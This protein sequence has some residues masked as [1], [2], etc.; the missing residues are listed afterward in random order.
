MWYYQNEIIKSPRAITLGNVTYPKNI[1]KDK[2]FLKANGI[3]PYYEEPIDSRYYWQG[4]KTITETDTEVVASYE[5]IPRLIDD[6]LEVN[7]DGSPML[8]EEGNQVVTKGL[9]DRLK[10]KN[11][12]EFKNK[13]QRPRVATGLGFDVDGSYQDLQ[14]FIVGKEFGV[15]DV[16]DADGNVH[17]IAIEDYDTIVNAIKAKGLEL[18]KAKWVAEAEIDALTT[19]EEIIAWENPVVEEV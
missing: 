12:Q 16:K 18:Y 6:R 11:S 5:A 2:E 10:Q 8:D 7:E 4:A 1:F 13:M 14:N 9:K 17:T 3:K 19:M 15:L